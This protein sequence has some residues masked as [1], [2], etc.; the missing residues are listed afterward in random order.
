MTPATIASPSPRT[1][2]KGKS[3]DST[4]GRFNAH[5]RTAG[6]GTATCTN[7]HDLSVVG[8]TTYA[9]G[10]SVCTACRRDRMRAYHRSV[11][12]PQPAVVVG[13]DGVERYSHAEWKRRL[14][15]EWARISAAPFLV[16][17][18]E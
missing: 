10:R 18:G 7:G 5:T 12:E 4:R 8:T 14:P 3:E 6:T 15:H 13:A 1:T 17:D 11:L 2:E 9:S 16:Q